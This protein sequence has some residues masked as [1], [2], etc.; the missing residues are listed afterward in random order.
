MAGIRL[1]GGPATPAQEAAALN[2]MMQGNDIY[3]CSWGPA[4]DGST[5]SQLPVTTY[6]ALRNGVMQ[7]R[8]GKGSIYV[9]ASGNGGQ[10]QDDCSMLKQWISHFRFRNGFF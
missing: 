5:V 8:G 9:F 6:K 7:G 4:D 1:I 2:H 10:Q 3:S